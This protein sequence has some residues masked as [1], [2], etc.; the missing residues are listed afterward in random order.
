MT[1]KTRKERRTSLLSKLATAKSSAEFMEVSAELIR[2]DSTTDDVFDVLKRRCRGAL[3]HIAI[4]I[5]PE[6][7]S[8][9]ARLTEYLPA[10]ESIDL[11]PLGLSAASLVNQV[12]AQIDIVDNSIEMVNRTIRTD[13]GGASAPHHLLSMFVDDTGDLRTRELDSSS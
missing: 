6:L 12:R 10:V 4:C 8:E 11:A 2:H 7:Q 3:A 13:S 9:R 5:L 1:H